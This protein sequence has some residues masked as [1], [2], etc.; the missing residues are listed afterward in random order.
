MRNIF[1]LTLIFLAQSVAVEAAPGH[2]SVR[3]YTKSNGTQV[4]SHNRTNHNHTQKDDWSSKPNRN[5]FTGKPG[6]RTPRH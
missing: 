2:H 5:P 6:T 1:L 3:G 4:R